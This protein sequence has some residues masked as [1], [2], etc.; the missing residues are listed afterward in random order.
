MLELGDA[1]A[2]GDNVEEVPLPAVPPFV[3]RQTI[4]HSLVGGS[5]EVE[6]KG[7]V[8]AKPGG[9]K[10]FS[11]QLLLEFA[12]DFFDKVGS[13]GVGIGLDI[14]AERSFAGCRGLLGGDLAVFKHGVDDQVAAAKGLVGIQNR[15]VS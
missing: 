8:D 9:V 5:L 1:N 11:S 2:T 12:T 7:G 3:G 15:R 14:E 10:L 6:I 13:D 4:E